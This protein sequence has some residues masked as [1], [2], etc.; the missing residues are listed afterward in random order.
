MDF[1]L[2]LKKMGKNAGKNISKNLSGDCSQK[3]LDHSQQSA[4][5]ALKTS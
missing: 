4:E 3:L 2:L 5:I 1:Y